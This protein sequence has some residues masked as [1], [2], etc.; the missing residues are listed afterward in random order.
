M[1]PFF[2]EKILRIIETSSS[3]S[4]PNSFCFDIDLPCE[5]IQS[6]P[7]CYF[8]IEINNDLFISLSIEIILVLVVV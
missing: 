8:S 7:Y 2:S 1:Q 4:F 3:K 5:F 6:I